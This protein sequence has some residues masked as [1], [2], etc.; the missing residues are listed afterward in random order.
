MIS[1]PGAPQ[2]SGVSWRRWSEAELTRITVIPVRSLPTQG[3]WGK[4]YIGLLIS[5]RSDGLKASYGVSSEC[6]FFQLYGKKN[7]TFSLPILTGRKKK[8]YIVKIYDG[9]WIVILGGLE[10]ISEETTAPR[11]N[12][13]KAW[14]LRSQSNE[15][16]ANRP[17]ITSSVSGYL[18]RNQLPVETSSHNRWF[19]GGVSCQ[20]SVTAPRLSVCSSPRKREEAEHRDR[21]WCVCVCIITYFYKWGGSF[22]L[23]ESHFLT[24]HFYHK[25]FRIFQCY[26]RLRTPLL[27]CS[28]YPQFFC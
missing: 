19:Q 17:R 22:T 28:T 7:Y 23:V 2:A 27:A 14:D 6:S 11:V 25:H 20:S 16:P 21:H 12:S 10:L 24:L 5:A 1:I 9:L 4:E 8:I 3:N 26:S 15:N 13:S 18:S